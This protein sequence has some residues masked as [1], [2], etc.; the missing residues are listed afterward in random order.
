[1]KKRFSTE[2]ILEALC[3]SLEQ[4]YSSEIEITR[5]VDSEEARDFMLRELAEEIVFTIEEWGVDEVMLE[6]IRWFNK[7]LIMEIL[8]K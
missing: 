6:D 5:T 7:D 3:Y 1:M 4:A 8:S 2:I